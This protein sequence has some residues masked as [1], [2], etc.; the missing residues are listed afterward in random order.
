MTHDTSD[1][2]PTPMPVRI[3]TTPDQLGAGVRA[4]RL[5][6]GISQ[7]ALARRAGTTQRVISQLENEPGG[8]TLAIVFRVLS[9]LELEVRLAERP[10]DP[11]DADPD[12]W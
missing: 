12:A 4:A 7:D 6:A 8:R 3:A 11:V 5:A 10:A 1:H 9:V 2:T